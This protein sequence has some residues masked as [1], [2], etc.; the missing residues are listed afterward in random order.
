[1]PVEPNPTLIEQSMSSIHHKLS[2]LL[3]ILFRGMGAVL[4]FFVVMI[5]S[6]VLGASEAGEFFFLQSIVMIL[7][8]VSMR[9]QPY[10]VVK[11]VASTRRDAEAVKAADLAFFAMKRTLRLALLLAFVFALLAAAATYTMDFQQLSPMATLLVLCIFPLVSVYML[12]G[13][14]MQGRGEIAKSLFVV[15]LL[16]SLVMLLA[17]VVFIAFQ[18]AVDAMLA[19]LTASVVSCGVAF[20]FLGGWGSEARLSEETRSRLV[21]SSGPLFV[22]AVAELGV[23]WAP[24]FYLGVLA[25][26][27]DVA[28]WNAI[29]RLASVVS[30][31][32]AAINYHMAPIIAEAWGEGVA[33]VVGHCRGAVRLALAL[34][35]AVVLPMILFPAEI[36]SYFGE[37]FAA[38]D[39]WLIVLVCA[40][41]VNVLG[42]PSG[43]ILIAASKE[44]ILKNIQLVAMLIPVAIL[45][46]F[47]GRYG[48]Q[49]AAIA[50]LAYYILFHGL[51]YYYVSNKL[52][53]GYLSLSN[54]AGKAS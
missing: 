47:L 34:V 21:S 7:A 6:R 48:V 22:F 20:L 24:T 49:A 46:F 35:S 12:Y 14:G 52:Q 42:A 40:N 43:L 53:V 4:S 31:L 11:L 23:F 8:I 54:E 39:T 33:A 2:P 5:F 16:P 18:G 50:S 28:Y 30:L 15:N 45:P 27:E 25:A 13:S 38:V 36:L 41:V 3:T 26:S 29:F 9:G 37:D 19:L 51:A 17:P 10:A 44:N 1:M 32:I